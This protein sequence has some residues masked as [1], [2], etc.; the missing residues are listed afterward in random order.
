MPSKQLRNTFKIS[1]WPPSAYQL[2]VY[3]Q[4]RV[5]E[6]GVRGKSPAHLSFSVDAIMEEV[7]A[8]NNN[9]KKKIT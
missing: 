9:K 1:Y 4:V 5:S 6:C 2:M 8:N 7:I 3:A